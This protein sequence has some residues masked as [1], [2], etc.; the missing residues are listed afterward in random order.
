MPMPI[1][2]TP[3]NSFGFGPLRLIP[4]LACVLILA[5]AIPA[6]SVLAAAPSPSRVPIA[7][8][9][10]HKTTAVYR[11][12]RDIAAAYPE[13]AELEEIGRSSFGR[14][15]FV[16][17]ITNKSTGLSLESLL[18]ALT[19]S[20][21][22]P[23][24]DVS[25]AVP[26]H[27]SKPG[28]W[29]C[30][31]THGNEYTGTEV[32]LYIIDKLVSGYGVDPTLRALVDTK[33][34][35]I[36]PIVSPDGHWNSLERGI[37]Q[38]GN[39]M[40]RDDDRDGRTNE[41]GPDD[42]DR[43]GV[44]AQFRYKDPKGRLVAD[45]VDPRLMVRLRN[46]ETTTR[47]TY[48]VVG[49][50]LDN[51]GDGRRGEDPESGIDINRNFPIRW[52]KD[53]GA[54]G[55]T[56]DF[57]ASS[58]EVKAFC[59]FFLAHRNIL[60]GQNYHTSGG[61]TY[62][63]M[64][65]S[66]HTAYH[67]KDVAVLDF[68]MGRKYL[69]LIGEEVPAVW[70]DPAGLDQAKAALAQGKNKLAALRGYELPRGWKVSY[71]E[72]S[73]RQYGFGL[74]TDWEFKHHGSYSITTELWNPA[75]DIPG[76]QAPPADPTGL[77]MQRALLAWQDAKYDG[78]LFIPWRP[79]L[80]PELGPGEIGGWNPLYQSNA[81]PGEPLTYVCE[82]HWKFELFRA[83]LLPDVVVAEAKARVVGATDDPETAAG[84]TAE[85]LAR[86]GKPRGPEGRFKAVEVTARI[87][88]RGALA[89]HLA[90]GAAIIGNREDLAWLTADGGQLRIVTGG[91][92]ARLGVLGGAL[93]IP[94]YK[95]PATA[96]TQ[97]PSGPVRELRWLAVVEGAA[98]LKIVVS[99]Q[100]GGTSTAEV[101]LR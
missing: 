18:P 62:R 83:G 86:A 40:L 99:S 43:D 23:A 73:D 39:S 67:P 26:A 16:L 22:N 65:S 61:F 13:I 87:E 25:P 76:F 2:S 90:Q 101:T 96:A 31:S 4:T 17:T 64:G 34:F 41:D 52:Y 100:K 57:P 37:S 32:C 12:L 30:G 78:K 47:P 7:F 8:N 36:C 46:E 29:I 38:R 91:S 44:I 74:S 55:G 35:Y 5:L 15:I 10:F 95:E 56:G 85:S 79:F 58:P 33:V 92:P 94:G 71:D 84:W 72:L 50:D 28:H 24:P 53:D 14:P 60:M 77:A 6:I 45:E 11:Y 1:H 54:A 9:E 97:A 48:T 69:E 93:P 49:E 70:K 20:T 42:L 63:P 88:N 3:S 21:S 59:D 89:T 68:I 98:P 81:W 80:H 51:D 66:P 82:T 75:R 27:L 19:S